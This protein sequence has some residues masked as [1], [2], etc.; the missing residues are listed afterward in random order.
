MS[1]PK[2]E[3]SDEQQAVSIPFFL[4]ENEMTRLERLNK[5]WFIAF[6][7]AIIMLFA[8]NAGWIIREFQYETYYYSQE[9]H[10]DSSDATALLNT[11]EGDINF[12]GNNDK[13]N[14]QNTGEESQPQKSDEAM[15]NL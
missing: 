8:T 14:A 13:A 11:G 6:L 12:N 10:S 7:V 3:F 4:H 1:E 2:K 15:P 9:V 5:R